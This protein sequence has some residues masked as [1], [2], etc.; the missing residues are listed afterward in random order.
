MHFQ[1]KERDRKEVKRH[2]VQFRKSC[3]GNYYEGNKYPVGELQPAAE[4]GP[5]LHVGGKEQILGCLLAG[6][7]KF[8]TKNYYK[9][10]R[11]MSQSCFPP[12]SSYSCSVQFGGDDSEHVA[13]A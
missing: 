9:Q 2:S 10:A 3:G 13:I 5:L 12:F 7:H 4:R 1:G 6:N 8:S 11:F